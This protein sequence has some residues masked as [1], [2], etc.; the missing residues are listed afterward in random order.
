MLLYN[1]TIVSFF[2]FSNFSPVFFVKNEQN[3]SP[4]P[5]EHG[6]L[7]GKLAYYPGI[8]SAFKANQLK[9]D[10]AEASRRDDADENDRCL[11]SYDIWIDNI[12]LY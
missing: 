2:N 7:R 3:P 10:E 1:I 9:G 8:F 6:D 4:S 11:I 12:Y 5:G